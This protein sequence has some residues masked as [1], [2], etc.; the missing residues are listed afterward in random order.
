MFD[1]FTERLTNIHIHQGIVRMEFAR[2]GSVNPETKEY[3]LE[4]GFRIAIPLD[5]FLHAADRMHAVK[6]DILAK[7]REQAAKN[8]GAQV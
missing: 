7:F 1:V 6:E 4:P 5:A 3:T 8:Q 2:L